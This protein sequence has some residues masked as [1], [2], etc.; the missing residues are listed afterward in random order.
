MKERIGAT[1]GDR[2][3]FCLTA[4]VIDLKPECGR[5][6]AIGRSGVSQAGLRGQLAEE[7]AVVAC[8]LSHVPESPFVCHVG[9]GGVFCIG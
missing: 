3:F 8:E 7:L 2:H 4:E 5:A 6:T 9:Y 1:E